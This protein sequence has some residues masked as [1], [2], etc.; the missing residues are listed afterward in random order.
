MV[1]EHGDGHC[2]AVFL[3]FGGF[4]TVISTARSRFQVTVQELEG[5][6]PMALWRQSMRPELRAIFSLNHGIRVCSQ[7]LG[8]LYD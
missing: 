2:V 4:H 1:F 8:S 6:Y 5:V 7:V 3:G